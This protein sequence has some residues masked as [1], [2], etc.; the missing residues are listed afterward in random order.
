MSRISFSADRRRVDL[1]AV[2]AY[3][4]KR[5]YWALGRKLSVQRR[6]ND[7][8]FVC[9]LYDGRKQA[10][11]ARVVTDYLV[12]AYICDVFVME[13]YR[14]RGLGKRLL[15]ELLRLPRF[16]TLR[17]WTLYTKDA[18]GL[19]RQSGFRNLKGPGVLRYM[20]KVRA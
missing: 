13:E 19:Y 7:A 11:F 2:H 6:I 1:K 10:A 3:L 12:Y 14:G 18:Q 5:S 17:R 16:K 15:R 8:S 20:E 4:S 9:G